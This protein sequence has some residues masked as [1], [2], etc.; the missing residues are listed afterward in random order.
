LTEGITRVETLNRDEATNAR[1]Q[2]ARDAQSQFTGEGAFS[3]E[4]AAEKEKEDDKDQAEAEKKSQGFFTKLFG[5][6][7]D[8]SA[9]GGGLLGLLAPL[10]GL[11]SAGGIL[12]FIGTI[13]API[14]AAI[15]AILPVLAGAITILLPI[16]LAGAAGLILANWID[17][18]S[19][20]LLKSNEKLMSKG[21]AFR[22][23]TDSTGKKLYKVEGEDGKI[24]HV[25]AEQLGKTDE[26]L[27]TEIE[28]D[29]MGNIS[30]MQHA[31]V[32][33]NGIATEEI[34]AGQGADAMLS[35]SLSKGEVSL[36]DAT[37][38]ANMHGYTQYRAIRE[39]MKK[40]QDSFRERMNGA[41]EN[42]GNVQK[43]VN[44][45]ND[46]LA[47]AVKAQA[48]YP[49]VF[50]TA[51]VERLTSPT[52]MPI[53]AGSVN[54]GKFDLTK[55]AEYDGGGDSFWG[56]V[57][58][59]EEF[60][61][62]SMG[63]LDVADPEELKGVQFNPTS[64]VGKLTEQIRENEALRQRGGGSSIMTDSNN[65]NV[66]NNSPNTTVMTPLASRPSG[67]QMK[68]GFNGVQFS[69]R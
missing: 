65:T 28:N 64:G 13:L 67:A 45:Y 24:S 68:V 63:G 10:L 9:E 58:D 26:Q 8:G 54:K 21:E 41:V 15:M 50:N 55:K 1:L 32:T 7:K 14:G 19:D 39:K 36:K 34:A 35:A 17:G 27:S 66:V 59:D 20:E 56:A 48:E 33:K 69:F 23:S 51:A 22:Q 37:I 42:D 44:E 53:F 52:G 43:L 12:G 30:K 5:R 3:E 29:P 25:T 46:I 16:I 49:S 40:F 4:F 47:A 38:M 57:L 11:F 6:K 61:H 18:Q 60:I 31:V 62:P 2:A